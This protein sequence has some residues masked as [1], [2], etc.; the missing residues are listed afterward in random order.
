MSKEFIEQLNHLDQLLKKLEVE[1]NA[2]KFMQKL[3]KNFNIE[4]H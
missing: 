2:I 3:N 1:S 4:K